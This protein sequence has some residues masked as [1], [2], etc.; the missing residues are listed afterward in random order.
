MRNC[1]KPTQLTVNF[2]IYRLSSTDNKESVSQKELCS[3]TLTSTTF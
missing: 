3:I 1:H 2:P